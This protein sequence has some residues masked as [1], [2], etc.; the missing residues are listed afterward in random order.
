MLAT[1]ASVVETNGLDFH[2]VTTRNSAIRVIE[3]ILFTVIFPDIVN[4]FTN[5]C[6]RIFH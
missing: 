6:L 4:C 1:Y 5:E 3:Q 2:S